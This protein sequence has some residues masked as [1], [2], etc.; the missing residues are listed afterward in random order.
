MLPHFVWKDL[1]DATAELGQ[2][3]ITVDPNWFAPHHEFRFPMLGNVC[4]QDVQLSLRSAIEPWYVMGEEPGGS[5]T[6]RFVDS[7]IERLELLLDGLDITR[8][9][10][11]CNGIQ[12]PLHSTGIQGQFVAGVRFRAWQPPRCLHPTIGVHSPLK[13]DILDTRCHQSIGGC[14]YHVA[15]PGGRGTDRFPINAN[16]AESRRAARFSFLGMTGGPIESYQAPPSTEVAPYPVTLDLRR[17][18]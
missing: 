13:F 6:T 12:V 17:F 4:Y 14:T 8:F 11:L 5:G 2:N 1:C 3:G 10:L 18:C 16:E 7:S 15:H 9:R